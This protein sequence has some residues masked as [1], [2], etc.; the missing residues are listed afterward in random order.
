ME[1]V[2]EYIT[3][4]VN[5]LHQWLE[6]IVFDVDLLFI[7][8]VVYCNVEMYYMN[9]S[10]KLGD[11]MNRALIIISLIQKAFDDELKRTY[12]FP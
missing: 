9:T 7:F 10:L 1:T 3:E 11:L 5:S 12:E 8:A 2:L 4:R 6:C